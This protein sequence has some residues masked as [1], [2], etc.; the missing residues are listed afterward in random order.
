MTQHPIQTI[1]HRLDDIR[2][3]LEADGYEL[4]VRGQDEDALEIEIAA[5]PDACEDCLVPKE[6]MSR[7]I[8][9]K[10]ELEPSHIKL[11]YPAD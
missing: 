8:A 2:S 10:L 9:T 1:T 6:I 7:I 11:N 4:I 5:T 3:G